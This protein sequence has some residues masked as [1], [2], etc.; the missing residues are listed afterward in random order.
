[1]K[2]KLTMILA[3]VASTMSAQML[4]RDKEKLD[5]L[6][7][8]KFTAVYQYSINTSDEE[9]KPASEPSDG[10]TSPISSTAT[11]PASLL[12][13]QESIAGGAASQQYE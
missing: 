6:C 3:F 7:Q 10:Q 4:T 2:T 13:G 12:T 11:R 5:T 8:T 9:G 1:M